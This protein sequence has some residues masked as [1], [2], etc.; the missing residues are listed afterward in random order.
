MPMYDFECQS[1]GDHQER[2]LPARFRDK[3]YL[4]ACGGTYRRVVSLPA[5]RTDG[6]YSYAP[7]I[8]DPDMAERT[9]S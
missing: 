6:I 8:G 3:G 7:N 4:C 1:C 2:L 5:K 9:G